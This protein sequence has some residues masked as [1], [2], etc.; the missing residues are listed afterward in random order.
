MLKAKVSAELY[1]RFGRVVE[2]IEGESLSADIIRKLR[3]TELYYSGYL[4]LYSNDGKV[5]RMY[6]DDRMD[7][8]IPMLNNILEEMEVSGNA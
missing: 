7:N 2:E 1:N 4:T 5:N 3:D 8:L 6:F